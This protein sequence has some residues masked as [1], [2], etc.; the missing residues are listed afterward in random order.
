MQVEKSDAVAARQSNKILYFMFPC[1]T[2]LFST[3]SNSGMSGIECHILQCIF[4]E[5]I[6]KVFHALSTACRMC[7]TK[8]LLCVK[9]TWAILNL[10]SLQN[11]LLSFLTSCPKVHILLGLLKCKPIVRIVCTGQVYLSI[12]WT[13][14]S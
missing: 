11:S 2:H 10:P 1:K 3:V 4:L 14:H 7:N 6:V 13:K 8:C 9:N 5:T 12:C